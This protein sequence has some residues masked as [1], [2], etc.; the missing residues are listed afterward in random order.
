MP[1]DAA[2]PRQL[3]VFIL[4]QRGY[5]L[6]ALTL[7]LL[8]L[9]LLAALAHAQ[10]TNWQSYQLGPTTYYSGTDANGGQWTGK[11]YEQWGTRFYE[12]TGPG[13]QTQ[14]CRAYALPGVRN[15]ECWP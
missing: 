15:T 12:F 9:L 7:W 3:P 6:G 5:R 1:L 8:V 2:K 13:G 11:S 10:P 14:H 4:L